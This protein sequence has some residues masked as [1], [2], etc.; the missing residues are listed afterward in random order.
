MELRIMVTGATGTMGTELVRQLHSMGREVVAVSRDL[1]RLPKDIKGMQVPLENRYLLEQAFRDV[2]VLVFIQPLCE[3]MIQQAENVVGAAKASGV[4]FVLKVSGLGAS[5][6]S[7]Y[8]YQRIQGEADEILI[9]SGLRYC[10]L[11][12]NIY[13]QC[14][15]KSHY[16][17]LMAGTLYLP[18]G[19][20]RTSYVDARD[21]ADVAA[22]LLQDPWRYQKR[23]LVLTG[24][25]ALSNAEAVS[26]ISH[27]ARR[28]VSYVPVTEEAARKTFNRE[29]S[30]WM[31]EAQMSLHRAAREGAVA[32]V[33]GVLR[34]ILGHDP[35]SF[36]EFCEDMKKAWVLPEPQEG[37]L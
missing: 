20:G 36:E 32:E 15:L 30:S 27:Y 4:Q 1:E 21:V 37:L 26:I 28:R 9:Q 18:Q 10:L 34:K 17:S 22:F 16:E 12:P 35:R 11:K 8:L 13:M 24:E 2:D 33:S 25:R 7:R 19:E 6:V 29:E 14:F 3:N 31:M 5:P 23:E